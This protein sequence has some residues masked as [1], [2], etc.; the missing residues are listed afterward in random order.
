MNKYRDFDWGSFWCGLTCVGIVFTISMF[1]G[2]GIG[3]MFWL[4]EK[5]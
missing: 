2:I 5:F 1:I 4:I 3:T